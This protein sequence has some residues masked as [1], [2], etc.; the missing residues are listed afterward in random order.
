MPLAGDEV[1][2]GTI[3]LCRIATKI[4]EG[5]FI[6]EPVY[7]K[8]GQ[9]TASFEEGGIV[10]PLLTKEEIDDAFLKME[11][12]EWVWYSNPGM[13]SLEYKQAI[14]MASFAEWLRLSWSIRNAKQKNRK[15]TLSMEPS[16][17]KFQKIF[18]KLLSEEYAAVYD[19]EITDANK[20]I[21]VRMKKSKEKQKKK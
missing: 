17:S 1:M 10:R 13:R 14:K 5:I 20:E 3:G 6:L 19:L 7:S 9:L 15:D 12:A 21:R 16:D 11:E 18:E 2:Y 8:T 4:S